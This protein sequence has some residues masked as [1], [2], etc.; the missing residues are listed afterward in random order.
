MSNTANAAGVFGTC[1]AGAGSP[2]GE[3]AWAVGAFALNDNVT[4]VQTVWSSYM[5]ARR[6]G[7]AGTTQG[8]E[9]NVI[10]G[11][12]V[13]QSQPYYMGLSGSTLGLW[14]GA[15]RNDATVP[16]NFNPSVAIGIVSGG[17]VARWDRGILFGHNSIN[18]LTHDG[19]GPVAIG[20]ATT[21][22]LVWYLDDGAVSGVGIPSALIRSDVT[23]VS[24]LAHPPSLLFGNGGIAVD[25]G[26]LVDAA[27]FKIGLNIFQATHVLGALTA[28]A[29]IGVFG[30]AAP[31]VVP[32]VTGAKGGNAALASLLTA[33]ASY[34]LIVDSS[35]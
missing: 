5:E 34:G 24:G 15:G 7:G 1:T 8:L 4:A 31:G 13:L 16:L 23:S 22:A 18:D 28:D 3:A 35:T 10:N 2:G 17:N 26:N 33:L 32:T 29:G 6:T 19:V 25:P 27:V 20:M 14:L 30:H 9:I 12:S 21:H 11:G